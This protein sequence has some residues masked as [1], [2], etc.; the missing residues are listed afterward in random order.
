M[1]RR[2]RGRRIFALLWAVLQFALPASATLADAR[3]AVAS[4]GRAHV[5]AT[6]GRDCAPAHSPDCAVCK[7]LWTSSLGSTQPATAFVSHGRDAAVSGPL[8]PAPRTAAGAPLARAP[9]TP[10]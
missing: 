10:V 9:P 7:H 6:P 2:R 8:A 1:H 4:P 5:E 3:M